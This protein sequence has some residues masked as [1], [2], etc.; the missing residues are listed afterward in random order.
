MPTSFVFSF[1]TFVFVFSSTLSYAGTTVQFCWRAGE[2]QRGPRC[3][4]RRNSDGLSSWSTSCRAVYWRLKSNRSATERR[5]IE[6]I[7]VVLPATCLGGTICAIHTL[8]GKPDSRLS[9]HAI[10]V[11]AVRIGWSFFLINLMIDSTTIFPVAII[12]CTVWLLP[13][14]IAAIAD[15]SLL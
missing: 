1:P 7:G 2:A 15:L 9:R 6:I 3:I 8:N 12:T 14:P 4:H 10:T 11:Q 13:W 5:R